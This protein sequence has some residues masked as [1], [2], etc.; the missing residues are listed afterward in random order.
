MLRLISILTRSR[1]RFLPFVHL[2]PRGR[3]LPTKWV[4]EKRS[5]QVFFSLRDGRSASGNC[6]SSF[7]QTS[8]NNGT[9]NFQISFSYLRSFW[10]LRASTN[11]S[12]SVISIRS[13][14]MR[15]SSAHTTSL[16]QKTTTLAKSFGTSSSSTKLTAYATST[17]RR[18]RLGT[19]SKRH[20][21]VGLR[22]CLQLRLSKIHS[23]NFSDSSA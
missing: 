18:T 15:S 3:F 7:H 9:K 12:S 5:K 20:L 6:L 22:S 19:P 8:V 10:R 14:G 11:R 13:C 21:L 23:W 17:S 1:P 2:Y 16:A 4:L